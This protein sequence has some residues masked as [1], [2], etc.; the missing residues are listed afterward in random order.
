MESQEAIH[1][2]SE[3]QI[4]TRCKRRMIKDI[5]MVGQMRQMIV[6][7]SERIV[8]TPRRTVTITP[9]LPPYHPHHHLLVLVK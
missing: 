6:L 2:I 4:K 7:I 3:R 9:P 5:E 1:L 8:R